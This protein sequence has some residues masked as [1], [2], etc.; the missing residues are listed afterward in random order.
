MELKERLKFCKDCELRKFNSKI[1]LVCSL[2]D[3]KPNF[4]DSCGDY[5]LDEI[6][7]KKEIT[8]KEAR[9]IG[10]TFPNGAVSGVIITLII[11]ILK[12]FLRN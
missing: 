4:I 8:R 11:I 12:M 5:K 9:L 6:A 1:G 3:E 7:V 2:T 10:D